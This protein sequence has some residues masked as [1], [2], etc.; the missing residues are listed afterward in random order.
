[1]ILA[2]PLLQVNVRERLPRPIVRSAHANLD[3]LPQPRLNHAYARRPTGFFNSLLELLAG[4]FF[5]LNT[6]IGP[7]N[8]YA[9]KRQD[10]QFNNN[11]VK[12]SNSE[13]KILKGYVAIAVGFLWLGMTIIGHFTPLG[14]MS[15]RDAFKPETFDQNIA[16]E[17]RDWTAFSEFARRQAENANSDEEVMV[18]LYETVTQR[19]AHKVANHT[20]FSNWLLALMGKL[21]PAFAAVRQPTIMVRHADALFCDQI[22]YLLMRLALDRGI[23][24]RHVGLYGHVVMEAWYDGKWHLFDPDLKVIPR[25]ASGQIV[26]VD[27]L[28]QSP[29][30]LEKYYG[31]LHGDNASMVEII[32]SV[33]NNSYASYPIGAW[34]EWKSNVLYWFEKCAELIKFIIPFLLIIFGAVHI[35]RNRI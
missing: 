4:N 5:R 22:S 13:M 23:R 9:L 8:I 10:H 19:F 15:Q 27:T 34:F 3:C 29:E 7:G 2:H 31:A 35:R 24:A 28:A 20:I 1:M 12:N 6:D 11:Q 21:H 26:S 33:E 25:N 32:R 16:R 18:S 14:D 17:L 30:L